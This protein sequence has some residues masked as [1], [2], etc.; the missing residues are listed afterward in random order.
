MAKA[1]ML[2]NR[3]TTLAA[4]AAV[5]E[6]NWEGLIG[7]ALTQIKTHLFF[8]TAPFADEVERGLVLTLPC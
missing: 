7:H 5:R 3:Q 1:W 8:P 6:R 4:S 2:E